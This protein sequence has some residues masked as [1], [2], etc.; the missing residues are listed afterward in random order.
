MTDHDLALLCQATYSGQPATWDTADVHAYLT[1][2]DG[3][4]NIAF[5]GSKSKEDWYR[6]FMVLPPLLGIGLKQHAQLG[7]VHYGLDNDVD[8]IFSQI[9]AQLPDMPVNVTGHSKGAGEAQDFAAKLRLLQ[10]SRAI[11]LT[12]FAPPR[13]GA[14]NGVLKGMPGK[15]YH[16]G[17]DPVP[18]VPG[19][20]PHPDGRPMSEL[21]VPP[22]TGLD[23]LDIFA[24]HSIGLYVQ[25]TALQGA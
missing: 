19:W 7:L 16:N 12:T 14:L 11:Y 3:Y 2:S 17:P 8:E 25:G 18:M 22:G 13:I 24:Y 20:L 5:K 15:D 10:P 1:T 21:W 6:D 4:A 23:L 9:I